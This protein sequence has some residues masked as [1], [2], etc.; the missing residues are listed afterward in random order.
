MSN[1]PLDRYLAILTQLDATSLDALT[2][3]LAEDVRFRDPFNDVRGRAAVRAV[4][5]DML[6]QLD[7]LRFAVTARAVEPAPRSDGIHVALVSWQLDARLPRLGGRAW[8]VAGCSEIHLDDR[9]HVRAHLDYWD[10]ARSLYEQLP[11]LGSVLRTLRRRLAV[12][13]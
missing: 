3:C 8:S 1:P 11:L 4:F 7:D 2:A 10:A 5:A 12:R 9:G 6:E 13:P